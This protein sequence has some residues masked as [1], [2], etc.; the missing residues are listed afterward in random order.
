M[1]ETDDAPA[2][3]RASTP[4]FSAGEAE[5][6]LQR[7]YGLA[8]Q[9]FVMASERDL[10]LGVTAETGE[11]YVLKIANA[12][13][14]QA[15]IRFQDAALVHLATVAPNLPVSR[16]VPTLTGEAEVLVEAEGLPHLVRLLTFLPGRPLSEVLRREPQMA[17]IGSLLGGVSRAFESFAYPVPEQEILWDMQHA[18]KLRRLTGSIADPA[19]RAPVEA[20]LDRFAGEIVP[21]QKHFRR[22]I[23]HNDFNPSNLLVA[24]GDDDCIAGILD[25]GDM[26]EAPRIFDVAVACSYQVP[27]EGPPLGLVATLLAACHP[28]HPLDAGE[29]EDLFDLISVRHAMTITI[30]EWRARRQPAN[31]AYILRNHPTAARAIARFADL[32]RRAATETLQ[33]ACDFA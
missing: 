3:F 26:V 7:F 10:T 9:V 6:I 23:I 14:D 8:G 28:V 4:P 33:R 24:E 12:A 30:G 2:A 1:T 31:A 18:A 5:T 21:R 22:Q 13:E 16:L 32:D 11:R 15:V 20:I 29:I 17:S 27:A 19:L 25:F